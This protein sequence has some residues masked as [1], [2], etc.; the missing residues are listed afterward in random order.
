MGD[1]LNI[2]EYC[3]NNPVLYRDPSGHDAVNQGNLYRN[4][5]NVHLWLL[6][7]NLPLYPKQGQR[8]KNSVLSGGHRNSYSSHRF[9]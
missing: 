8:V 2:Y 4:I 1:G 9:Y 6:C 3:R 7:T 5:L